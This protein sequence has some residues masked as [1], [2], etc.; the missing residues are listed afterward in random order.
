MSRPLLLTALLLTGC[1]AEPSL[2]DA[3]SLP[4]A[5]R[6]AELASDEDF[7]VPM[8]EAIQERLVYLTETVRGRRYTEEALLARRGYEPMLTDA[9]ERRGLPTELVAVVFVESGFRNIAARPPELPGGGLWQFIAPTARR[10][11]LRVD[12]EVDERQDPDKETVAALS[13]LSDLHRRYGDWGLA[14]TAYNVGEARVDRVIA[15]QGTDDVYELIET[16]AL[17]SYAA[18]VMAAVIVLETWE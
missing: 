16:D 17:P 12:D 8:N 4:D 7:T 6:L 11:G 1:E 10:Y 14:F 3:P 9:I 13:L 5:E 2:A 18:D 15:E